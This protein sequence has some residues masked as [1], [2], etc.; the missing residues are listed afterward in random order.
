LIGRECLVE[1]ISHPG[2]RST[3]YLPYGKNSVSNDVIHV[4]EFRVWMYH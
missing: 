4:T 2:D 3:G 1:I